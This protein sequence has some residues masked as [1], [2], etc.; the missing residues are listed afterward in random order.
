MVQALDRMEDEHPLKRAVVDQHST[1]IESKC[2]K[3]VSSNLLRFFEITALFTDFLQVD[4]ATWES[5]VNFLGAK[6]AV[7][8]VL[9]V[10]DIGERGVAQ[11]KEYNKLQTNDGQQKQYLL[12]VVRKYRKE[13]PTGRSPL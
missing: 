7:K 1:V 8:A 2:L 5:D 10:K 3:T 11:I 12:L 6:E 4:L 9:A 13:H